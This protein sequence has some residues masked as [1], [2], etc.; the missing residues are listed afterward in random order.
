[1]S[2]YECTHTVS[3]A[4]LVSLWRTVINGFCIRNN[5]AF[6]AVGTKSVLTFSRSFSGSY[7]SCPSRSFLTTTNHG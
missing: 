2:V 4:K 1:M 5:A 6:A 3:A 7:K